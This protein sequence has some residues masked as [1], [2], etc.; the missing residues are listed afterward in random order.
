MIYKLFAVSFVVCVALFNLQVN[1]SHA[2]IIDLSNDDIAEAIEYGKGSK[3]VTLTDF[4]KAWDVRLGRDI[5]WATLYTGFHNLAFKARKACIEHKELTQ[6]EITH[7]LE[8]GKE[9]TFTATILGYSRD[10]AAEYHAM[11]KVGDKFIAPIFEFAP[12][13]AETSE[14]WPDQPASIAGCV[15][16]FPIEGVEE[17]ALVT[18]ILKPFDGDVLEFPF[19]LSAMK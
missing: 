2:V 5:G 10:F 1:N 19:D 17:N 15:Y 8:I 6:D 12:E 9:L 7:A 14:Y 11:L 16:K 18:L 3:R 13:I 4:T